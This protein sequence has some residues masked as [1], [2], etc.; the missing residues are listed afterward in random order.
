MARNLSSQNNYEQ[1]DSD[2][3]RIYRSVAPSVESTNIF[4]HQIIQG[5]GSDFM[6]ANELEL[7]SPREINEQLYPVEPKLKHRTKK[8]NVSTPS[9][10]PLLYGQMKIK[11]LTQPHNRAN[12]IV[13]R[14]PDDVTDSHRY[15]SETV[16]ILYAKM[17]SMS[18]H[19][20]FIRNKK[21][22]KFKGSF[23]F[24]YEVCFFDA[25]VFRLDPTIAKSDTP[26]NVYIIEFRRR[27][28]TG[29][30]AFHELFRRIAGWLL[31][32]GRA[33]KY[34]NGFHIY[35]F[36]EPSSNLVDVSRIDGVFESPIPNTVE[37]QSEIDS[38]QIR[39]ESDMISSWAK[40]ISERSVYSEENIRILAI[41]STNTE[42]LEL[43]AHEPKLLVA[44]CEELSSGKN[45][46]SSANA[47][48]NVK[49]IL[50][51]H[52]HITADSFTRSGML[53]AITECLV[54]YSGRSVAIERAALTT[55]EMLSENQK[56]SIRQTELVEVLKR[57]EIG[58]K[59][60]LSDEKNNRC[61]KNVIKRM[62]MKTQVTK[63]LV[64]SVAPQI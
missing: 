17:V 57:L 32:E 47:L 29:R 43:M 48:V 22:L 4:N 6:K 18:P 58:L 9:F 53:L 8:K 54:L 21:Y 37:T 3:D 15:I 61:L 40:K 44:L 33:K 35:P 42:S 25:Q 55:L 2:V 56:I 24:D 26:E 34:A 64:L 13:F 1:F 20:T 5:K 51:F 23:S 36:E 28:L 39:L 60:G 38:C 10:A 45:P 50:K 30:G 12:S 46:S 59:G 27:S 7:L 62:K 52:A 11:N 16:G 31:N 63:I 49:A 19:L 41:C 14:I